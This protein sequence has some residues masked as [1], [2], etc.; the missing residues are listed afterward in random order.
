MKDTVYFG[1]ISII[2]VGFIYI[3]NISFDIEA[4]QVIEPYYI[5]S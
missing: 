3:P 5:I 2:P 4:L 1:D